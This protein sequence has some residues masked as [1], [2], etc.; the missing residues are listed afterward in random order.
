MTDRRPHALDEDL[1]TELA[2]H[3]RA[4]RSRRSAAI[5]VGV[6]ESTVGRWLKLASQ[7]VAPYSES[8]RDALVA[9]TEFLDGLEDEVRAGV[10]IKG[11][12]DW[13]ARLAV[14]RARRPDEWGQRIR[15]ERMAQDWI[16][17]LVSELDKDVER[18]RFDAQA[19]LAFLEW[20]QMRAGSVPTVPVAEGELGALTA[21]DEELE[22]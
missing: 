3:L 8:L 14:L 17:E 18:G 5:R 4:G 21:G 19:Y 22:R 12:E 7:G 6:P 10:D 11:N 1:A 20:L 16:R 2:E 13:K 9:E 15:I